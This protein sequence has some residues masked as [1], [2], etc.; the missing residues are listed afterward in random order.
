MARPNPGR[1]GIVL[2]SVGRG[3]PMTRMPPV[4]LL[5]AIALLA[6]VSFGCDIK[7]DD[8]KV[9]VDVSRGR[10]NDEWTRTYTVSKGGR[11]ELVNENGDIEVRGSEGSQIAVK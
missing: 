9:S 2:S 7:V 8:G 1:A 11:F 5:P 10:A 4:R 3:R 6:V